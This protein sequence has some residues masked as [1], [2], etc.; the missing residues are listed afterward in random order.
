MIK[1]GG[2]FIAMKSK[3]CEQEVSEAKHALGMLGAQVER[4]VNYTIPGTDI[5]HSLVVIRKKKETPKQFPRRFN[6]ITASPL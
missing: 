6:K 2:L 1:V 3:D 4:I 5:T